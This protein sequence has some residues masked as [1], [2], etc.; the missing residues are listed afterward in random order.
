M[1]RYEA[2]AHWLTWC[3]LLIGAL[4]SAAHAELPSV[5]WQT[6]PLVTPPQA[7]S[8]FS[9]DP[10]HTKGVAAMPAAAP[11]I[12][13]L[14]NALSQGGACIN[15]CYAS[16]VYQYVRNNIAMEFRFGLGKGGRG[17]L[18]DQSGTPCG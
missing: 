16:L 6:A 7:W 15:S 8:H 10:T 18:I 1:D 3:A 5:K 11:E 2:R 12:V 13:E 17:A 14:S 9:T 4:T